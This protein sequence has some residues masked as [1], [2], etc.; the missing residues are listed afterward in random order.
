MSSICGIIAPSA[1]IGC[2]EELVNLSREIKDKKIY[3]NFNKSDVY[4]GFCSQR[5]KNDVESIIFRGVRYSY[6]FCGELY[7]T[8]Y[9]LKTRV[10]K[11][12]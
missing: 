9:L 5:E 7:N 10:A 11:S 1:S 3:E 4:V 6:S 12:L 2:Y 8:E